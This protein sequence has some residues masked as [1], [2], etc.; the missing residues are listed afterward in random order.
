M[1][2]E[3]QTYTPTS[4]ERARQRKRSVVIA[5]SLVVLVILFF[6]TTMVRLSSNISIQAGG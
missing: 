6:V 5:W 2:E 4:E 3:M 1:A